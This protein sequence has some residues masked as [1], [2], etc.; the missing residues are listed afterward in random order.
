MHETEQSRKPLALLGFYLRGHERTL[1]GALLFALISQ[2]FL[3]MDP[4]I[5]RHV[6]DQYVLRRSDFS[7]HGFLLRVIFWLSLILV[8]ALI[9]W[10]ARGFQTQSV[11]S[12]AQRVSNQIYSDGMSHSLEISYAELEQRRSGDTMSQLQRT[13]REVELF[14]TSAVN[15]LF[16]SLVGLAFVILYAARLHWSVP[17]FLVVTAPMVM[18]FSVLLSRKV[19][20]TQEE[21]VKQSSVLAGS[22]GESL[23]NMELVKSLGLTGNEVSRFRTGS[24]RILELE[25]RRIRHARIYSFFHGAGVHIVRV[26]LFLLLLYLFSVGKGTVGQFFS[27]FLYS[28]FILGPMQDLGNVISQYRELEASLTAFSELMDHP[29]ESKPVVPVSISALETLEFDGVSFTYGI[30]GSGHGP[31]AQGISFRASR[32][33]TIAFVGQSGAGKSTLIK[34]LSGLY[35]PTEGRI[36]FN[37]ISS[38]EVDWNSLRNRTGLVTQETHLFSGTIRENLIFAAP[39]ATEDE[40]LLALQQAAVTSLLE[41]GRDGLDSKVGEGGLQLSGGER[42]RLAI[43]RALLR[44][45]QLVL[46]DEATSALDSITEQAIGETIRNLATANQI[47]SIVISHRLATVTRADC[48]YVLAKGRIIESGTHESLLAENGL[49]CDMWQRQTGSIAGSTETQV[50]G[51]IQY[52]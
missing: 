14:L 10:V 5:L 44:R 37:G 46:F 33:E 25:L 34:L 1:F 9:A 48:I 43:A 30:T 28:Y 45:P 17:L 16:T 38:S 21:I 24:D 6:L 47:I 4:L 26:S 35:P 20:S 39:D 8:A 41:R 7:P 15:V 12:L 13:R 19:R 49:Y 29:R 23:R 51:N 2:I 50:A 36:L 32:G 22:A 42:Q 52:Q 31:A 18:F 11:C 3:M 40:C 27:L